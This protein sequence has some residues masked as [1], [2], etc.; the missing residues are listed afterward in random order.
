VVQELDLN[1][2]VGAGVT[3]SL[4]SNGGSNA[5]ELRLALPFQDKGVLATMS[6]HSVIAL[7]G[8][9]FD[10]AHW[11][12]GYLVVTGASGTLKLKT[13]G[14]HSHQTFAVQADPVSGTDVV[15]TG[16]TPTGSAHAGPS[17]PFRSGRADAAAAGVAGFAH[18]IAGFYPNQA[19]TLSPL[20]SRETH[21]P[22]PLLSA[23][24]SRARG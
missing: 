17:A 18:A 13:S 20:A 16:T 5:G 14:D 4:A 10:H 6:T 3:I 11:A 12:S 7:T 23:G 8:H 15:V 21:V 19:A 24:G 2:P 1:G 22:T 9:Q